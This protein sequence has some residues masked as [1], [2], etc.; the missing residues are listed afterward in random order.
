[1]D[2]SLANQDGGGMTGVGIVGKI[3]G[4]VMPVDWLEVQSGSRFLK[5]QK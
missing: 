2:E 3:M 4:Q 1:V 5:V